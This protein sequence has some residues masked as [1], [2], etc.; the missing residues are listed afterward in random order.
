MK[1]I[2]WYGGLFLLVLFA[3]T[4]QYLRGVTIPA[5]HNESLFRM[6]LRA[7]HIYI[8]FVGLV[9]ILV[10]RCAFNTR[11]FQNLAQSFFVMCGVFVVFAFLLETDGDLEHRM[12]SFLTGI[13]ALIGILFLIIDVHKKNQST[14]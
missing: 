13:T 3:L 6:M 10:S 12:F 5:E 9:N 7:N 1:K 2:N 11:V 8:L 14:E 4:G